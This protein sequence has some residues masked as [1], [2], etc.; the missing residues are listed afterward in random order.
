LQKSEQ[1]FFSSPYEFK[2]VK[3]SVLESLKKHLEEGWDS[4]GSHDSGSDIWKKYEAFLAQTAPQQFKQGEQKT[5]A[6]ILQTSYN[7]TL[8]SLFGITPKSAQFLKK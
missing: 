1:R 3:I 8:D 2:R 6:Q 4:M 7:P 5:N